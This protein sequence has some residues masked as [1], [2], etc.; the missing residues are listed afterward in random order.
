MPG[1]DMINKLGIIFNFDNK[2]ST[3]QEVSISMIS[4]NCAA[5]EFI[6]M[7]ESRPVR[8]ASKNI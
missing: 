4:P 3:W 8:N 6:V 2:T 5:K 7:K 1:R